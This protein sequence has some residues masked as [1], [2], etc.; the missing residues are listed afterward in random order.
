MPMM[1]IDGRAHCD[2]WRRQKS[3]DCH[4]ICTL[5]ALMPPPITAKVVVTDPEIKG[6]VVTVLLS[7]HP[8]VVYQVNIVCV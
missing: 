2:S 3:V 6:Q 8:S 5:Y 4:R 7:V 1:L